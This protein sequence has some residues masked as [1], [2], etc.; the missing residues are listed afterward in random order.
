MADR[1]GLLVGI[2]LGGTSCKVTVLT[3]EGRIVSESRAGY[4]TY[5]PAPGWA[6]QNA[7]DW[8]AAAAAAC[9]EAL[10]AA[11]RVP[12]AAVGFSA[13]THN[14]VLLDS[15]DR[16]VRRSILLTDLRAAP[17]AARLEAAAGALPLE[18]ARNRL[19]TGWTLPQLRWV[20]EEEPAVWARMH[21]IVFAKDYVRG[22]LTGDRVTDW[23]DAEGS[24]LLDASTHE[25]E[26]ALCELVPIERRS[27]PDVV[28]PTRVVG[29]VSPNGARA[30]GLPA[31]TPVVAGCSDTA[32]EALAC[33]ANAPGA[34]IVKIATAGNVNVVTETP[35]PSTRYFTYTHPL[36]GLAYHTFGTNAAATCRDWLGELLGDPV[37][38][39]TREAEAAALP[40]GAEGL[41][42]HPYLRGE[43]APVYD[44]TLRASFVGLTSR[45]GAAHLHRA[46]LEGVALSLA[47][48]AE[49]ARALGFGESVRLV[50]GGAR[51]PLWAQIV[52][53]ALAVPLALPALS[54]ASAG[55]ALVA[56]LGLGVLDESD[57]R[58]VT[59]R[60]AGALRPDAA[61]GE[62][63]R[64]LLAVYRDVRE[65]LTAPGRALAAL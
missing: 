42:F 60:A 25:W 61:A 41:L 22:S 19:T 46:V 56:G 43:R 50:G 55:V 4:T 33:G 9:R 34:G 28:A 17:Q 54:D 26:E 48:C 35:Q 44:P 29:A 10:A 14:A 15:A 21:R 53:D 58:T 12:V 5:S 63:Y 27:L 16:P 64:R 13:A 49:E 32:A 39:L 1:A 20:A 57:V 18:V 65:A 36:P 37:A 52:C 30:F 24:L 6:E 8:T 40:P 2:D 38:A 31:G 7:D 59:G 45:H 11:G 47:E 23:I 62:T 3:P 51:S